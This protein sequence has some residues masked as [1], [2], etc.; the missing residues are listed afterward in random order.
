VRKGGGEKALDPA[1]DEVGAKLGSCP[2]CSSPAR[3]GVDIVAMLLALASEHLLH[4]ALLAIPWAYLTSK[5]AD[6]ASMVASLAT[7]MASLA[8]L[9]ASLAT[10]EGHL[11]SSKV[12]SPY[13]TL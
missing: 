7:K 3:N 6:L 8:T 9:A 4:Q 2:R 10:L 11:A 12:L 13:R 5:A 1:L